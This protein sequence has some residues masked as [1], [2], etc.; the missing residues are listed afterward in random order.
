V[1]AF[2]LDPEHQT[3][4]VATLCL[5]VAAEDLSIALSVTAKLSG[6]TAR[7]K[8]IFD[9]LAFAPFIVEAIG[10]SWMPGEGR[11]LT[12]CILKCISSCCP[13][14]ATMIFR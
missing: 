13:L 11:K 2:S 9:V 7:W 6:M 8:K 5:A 3:K 12:M 1:I 14:L 10:K 4:T